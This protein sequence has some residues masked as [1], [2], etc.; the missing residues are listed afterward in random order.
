MR[1]LVTWRLNRH[2]AVQPPWREQFYLL[3]QKH[4]VSLSNITDYSEI[5]VSVY[6]V[7]MLSS[8]IRVAVLRGGPSEEYDVSLKTG[9]HVLSL[10]REMP[11]KYDPIDIFISRDGEWHSSGLVEEPHRALRH[12]NVVWNA[13]HG[14][15]G[16]DGQVQRELEKLKIPFTGSSSLSSAL[17][18]NKDMAKKI[19]IEH[20]ILVPKHE[21]LVESDFSDEKLIY[22]FQNYLHPVIIKP[23]RGSGGIGVTLAKSFNELKEKVKNIF[24]HSP[25]AIVEEYIKGKDATCAVVENARGEKMYALIPDGDLSAAHKKEVERLTK[26][27]HQILGLRHY[28]SSDFVVTPKGKIYL[29]ETNAQPKFHPESSLHQSLHAVGWH[30][31]DFVDHVLSLHNY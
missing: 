17:A 23:S 1:F 15:Y 22:I 9:A 2:L 10:L 27:S 18:I 4:I 12:A 8:K 25:K 31:R 16:E 6:N 28:S 19:F 11:E 29:I 7:Y 13:L 21:V 26:L 14:Q 5:K 24:K 30:P 20:S 3:M